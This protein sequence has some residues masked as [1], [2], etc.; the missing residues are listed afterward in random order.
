MVKTPSDLE[1][2]YRGNYVCWFPDGFGGRLDV[3][4]YNGN[5]YMVQAG[6]YQGVYGTNNQC[7]SIFD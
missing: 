4:T 2:Y 3:F 5:V 7:P 6:E 1:I